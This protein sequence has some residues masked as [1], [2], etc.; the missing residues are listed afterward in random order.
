M[1]SLNQH[2]LTAISALFLVSTSVQAEMREWTSS[3]G[4]KLEAEFVGTSGAGA[5]AL[6][7]LKMP[8]GTTV[9]YPISK[10]S[11][12]DRVFVKSSLPDDPMALAA[13][14]DKLVL[15]NMK[16]SYYGL[17]DE[18]VAIPQNTE[19][20]NAEKAKRRAEIEREMKMCVPND[21]TNDSQFMR[22]IYLDLA[23]RI[24]TY[25]EAERFLESRSATKRADL[26]NELLETEAFSMRMFNYFSDLLRVR[27]SLVMGGG[28]QLKAT[29]Y[30]EWIKS[31]IRDDKPYDQFVREMLTAEGTVWDNPA[32]GYMV[33]DNGMRLCNVSNTFTVF[34][35]TEITCAQCHDHPFEQVKQIDFYRMASFLGEYDT[36]ARDGMNYRAEVERMSK[37]LLDAGKL[38]PNTVFDNRLNLILGTKRTKVSDTGRQVVELPHDYKYDNGEPN[39]QVAPAAYFGDTVNL[40][41]YPNPRLAFADWLTSPGN[42]R[43]TVN[44]VNRLWKLAFGLGQ[45]EPV[46]NI[47]GHLDGQAENYELLK[48]L[49]QMMVDQGYSIKDFFRVVCN[50]QTYQRKSE[51]M[52]PTLTQIDNGS[53]HFPGPILR[54]MSAEQLWDSMV[55]LTTANPDEMVSRGAVEYREVMNVDVTELKTADQ[56]EDFKMRFSR[57]GNITGGESTM[58]MGADAG[59]I[60]G[61][62]MVRASEMP[63]PQPPGHF[64]RMFG[65][66]DKTLIENQS[67]HGSTPQVMALLNGSITNKVLTS[68]DAYLIK[69]I[70][71]GD[72][73]KGD[74][75]DKIFLSVLGRYPY[76]HEKRAAASGLRARN[77]GETPR[78]DEEKEIAAIGDV[79]WA[80][81]NTR[82]FIFV[83]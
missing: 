74:K 43:F 45:I 15:N 14:I 81:V 66:S 16:K 34:L 55:T 73:K 67:T 38:R 60:G 68:P 18:F 41:K 59:R 48:F 21:M 17:R 19:L 39:Q 35:G 61:E 40:E 65:Q 47:P 13:E 62:R 83:Q 36:R 10:L 1:K 28:G 22:R 72:G 11:A 58:M 53:Y 24:P 79:I 2:W 27:D 44:I 3:D 26:I 8:N 64:L 30:I 70:A 52:S 77:D 33:T 82:E 5:T 12:D 76:P 56:I 31:S 71:Y 9:S 46:D 78:S 75:I 4:K 54:R 37:V 80:L 7:K 69:E 49:E 20:T 25:D 63:A 50:T 57:I 32:T 6:V 29:A 51:N 42:P 23:G